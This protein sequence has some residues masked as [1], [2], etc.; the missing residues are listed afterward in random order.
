MRL[1]ATRRQAQFSISNLSS[2]QRALIIHIHR[3]TAPVCRRW[4]ACRRTR[5]VTHLNHQTAPHACP[6]TRPG[7]FDTPREVCRFEGTHLRV[8][9]LPPSWATETCPPGWDRS[10]SIG[11]S[12]TTRMDS[13]LHRHI[14][15][16]N[17]HSSWNQATDHRRL[18]PNRLTSLV[19]R[20]A[21]GPQRNLQRALH[22]AGVATRRRRQS[23]ARGLQAS[24]T[25]ATRVG[26]AGTDASRR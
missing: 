9:V 14:R 19:T 16:P 8:T 2:P 11:Q 15:R 18:I 21:G 3:P 25:C 26:C 1:M 6:R 4:V 23:G 12:T 10:T 24:R 17:L 13:Y 7:P 22:A 5:P 20:F